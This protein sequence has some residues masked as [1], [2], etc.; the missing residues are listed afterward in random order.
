MSSIQIKTEKYKQNVESQW[1]NSRQFFEQK[2]YRAF[3][4]S[5]IVTNMQE[6]DA[7]FDYGNAQSYISIGECENT[8]N[9]LERGYESRAF[10]LVFVKADPIFKSLHNEPRLQEILRKM[11]LNQSR[12]EVRVS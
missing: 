6:G 7:G 9:A 4:K 1:Q 8:L 3:L 12:F 10:M 5:Q 2:G 11:A